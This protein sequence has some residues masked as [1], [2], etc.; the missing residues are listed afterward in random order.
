MLLFVCIYRGPARVSTDFTSSTGVIWLDDVICQGQEVSI[1]ECRH[2]SWARHNCDHSEDVGIVCG[3]PARKP[4]MTPLPSEQKRLHEC[5]PFFCNTVSQRQICNL[6]T[7]LLHCVVVTEGC[8]QR[9][10]GQP[11]SRIVGGFDVRY[12]AFPWQAAVLKHNPRT[13]QYGHWCGGT[14]ISNSWVLSAAH[15]FV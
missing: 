5:K 15:C 4:A 11:E 8:G 7:G 14:I 1:D 12:G 10:I 9:P 6:I 3:V 13:Q 2:G